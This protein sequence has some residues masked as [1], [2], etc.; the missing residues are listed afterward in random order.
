MS[1]EGRERESLIEATVSAFRE[2][3]AEGRIC[4]SPAWWDLSPED[5]DAAFERQLVARQF[6]R[7]Y[8]SDGLSA[9]ARAVLR[10]IPLLPQIQ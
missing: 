9:T 10:R 5:R 7:A 2:R 8:D 1:A 6:E 4:P 3:D